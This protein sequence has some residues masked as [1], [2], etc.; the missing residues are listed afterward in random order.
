MCGNIF[1]SVT[2]RCQGIILQKPVEVLFALGCTNTVV[3]NTTK[4]AQIVFVQKKRSRSD[5]ARVYSQ[6]RQFLNFRSTARFRCSPLLKC[7]FLD[8]SS[9]NFNIFP[10]PDIKVIEGN[11][12]SRVSRVRNAQHTQ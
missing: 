12:F 4:L 10:V 7:T 5:Q 1:K 8:F 6:M 9:L 3:S 2:I 11:H